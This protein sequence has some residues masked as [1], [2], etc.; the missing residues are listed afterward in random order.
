MLV[1]A[2]RLMPAQHS[3]EEDGNVLG[4]CACGSDD[5]VEYVAGVGASMVRVVRRVCDSSSTDECGSSDVVPVCDQFAF[6]V[7]HSQAA[8]DPWHYP[9]YFP[10][11][12]SGNDYRTT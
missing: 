3:K 12:D 11:N 6:P 8:D 7:F 5:C 2:C 1:L 10:M 9:L 4:A